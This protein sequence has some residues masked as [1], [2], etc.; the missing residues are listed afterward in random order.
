MTAPGPALVDGPTPAP[1]PAPAAQLGLVPTPALTTTTRPTPT[2]ARTFTPTWR[3]AIVLALAVAAA[4]GV[5]T[6]DNPMPVGSS[7]FWTIARMRAVSV[8]TIVVV[9]FAQ[10]VGT[11]V[12]QTAT[13]NRILTPS[14]LGFDALYRVMQTALVFFFGASSLAAT[15]GLPKIAAQTVLMVTFAALI[16]GVLFRSER[17]NLHVMLLMGMVMGLGLGSLSTFMQRL[18]TPS[19]FDILSARLFGNISNSNVAYLPW[20]AGMCLLVGAILWRRRH[21]LDVLALGRETATTLGL[22]WRREIM[23]MLL[24]V[25]VLISVSTTLV[26][27]MTF[28]GFLVV[29]L[30]YQL[31][32]S[33]RHARLLPMAVALGTLTLM[34]AYFILRHV[35]YAGGLVSVIIEFVGG[36]VFLTHL[37]RK[38]LR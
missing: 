33:S 18:L 23:V 12:F 5:L 2:R 10:A 4:I 11:L 31:A 6:W 1:A 8:A 15:D 35:F 9:A 25:S 24:L 7:G 16:F 27:P 38:G 28:F 32:G 21:V 13:S 34:G 19:E 26:G 14:I 29:T 20:G 17:T 37:L 36:L 3:L 30:T 22:N